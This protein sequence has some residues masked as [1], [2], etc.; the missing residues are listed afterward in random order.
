MEKITKKQ[1]KLYTMLYNKYNNDQLTMVFN[2]VILVMQ[3]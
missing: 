2:F 1:Y 3:K